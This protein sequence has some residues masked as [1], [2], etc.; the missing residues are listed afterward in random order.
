MAAI[1][2]LLGKP[3]RDKRAQGFFN[4]ADQYIQSQ[5]MIITDRQP[6]T[7]FTEKDIPVNKVRG[8]IQTIKNTEGFNIAVKDIFFSS[9]LT[10]A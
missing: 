4:S 7:Y 3:S 9:S 5:G 8:L 2:I 10:K 1:I 6:R